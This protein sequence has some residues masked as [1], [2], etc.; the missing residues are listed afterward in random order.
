MRVDEFPFENSTKKNTS[1][2]QKIGDVDLSI[3]SHLIGEPLEFF[4]FCDIRNIPKCWEFL[5]TTQNAYC[6]ICLVL[7]FHT[8]FFSLKLLNT[9]PIHNEPLHIDCSCMGSEAEKVDYISRSILYTCNCSSL[10]YFDPYRIHG[11]DH[12]LIDTTKLKPIADWLT[13]ISLI[14]VSSYMHKDFA[15]I[16][17]S[18]WLLRLGEL[19]E[20]HGFLY[21]SAFIKYKQEPYRWVYKTKSIELSDKLVHCSQDSRTHFAS[22]SWSS[23]SHTVLVY[24]SIARHIR[25]HVAR[26]TEYWVEEFK[27]LAT[28]EAIVLLLR[29]NPKAKLAFI[30]LLWA[31]TIEP[32][33]VY[34]RWDNRKKYH[35]SGDRYAFS[36]TKILTH[37]A[38]NIN[39]QL[40]Y[41][42]ENAIQNWARG[43]VFGV[44][45][46]AIWKQ[47]EKVVE[48]GIKTNKLFWDA[49]Q[50]NLVGLFSTSISKFTPKNSAEISIYIDE[51]LSFPK[52]IR[53]SKLERVKIHH[54]LYE[55]KLSQYENWCTGLCLSWS[56]REGW[57][58]SESAILPKA[59]NLRRVTVT[60]KKKLKCLLYQ[61]NGYFV[62]R[63]LDFKLKVFSVE[64]SNIFKLMRLRFIEYCKINDI[65]FFSKEEKENALNTFSNDFQEFQLEYEL[66][67]MLSVNHYGFCKSAFFIRQHYIARQNKIN[68]LYGLSPELG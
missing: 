38:Y 50:I 12:K 62:L 53:L 16:Y 25:R 40:P 30:E 60:E 18:D 43:H 2:R 67:C 68:R 20:M 58:T 29:S 61:S 34:K 55:K 24:K 66:S 63:L 56:E 26:S 9:C 49:K 13:S 22:N 39:K 47:A 14:Q 1:K 48:N 4:T 27:R 5:F 51:P 57:H 54:T 32:T 36:L 19:S 64:F 33:S 7:G 41:N 65:T 15:S 8:K 11:N 52:I 10:K 6:P 37:A 17:E 44:F 31:T 42:I 35:T 28:P 3:L 21:P 59:W 45:S 46:L 23:D